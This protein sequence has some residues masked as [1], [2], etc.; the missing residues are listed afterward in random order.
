MDRAD[1]TVTER[2]NA[3]PLSTQRVFQFVCR[4]MRQNGGTAPT[5]RQIEQHVGVPF[6]KVK[7][8]Y[9]KLIEAGLL[10]RPKTQG[11]ARNIQVASAT[12]TIEDEVIRALAGPS[13]AVFKAGS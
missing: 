11:K 4:H 8:H 6:K 3:L 13:G 2:W 12:W 10:I 1:T 7:E 5:Y 9:E